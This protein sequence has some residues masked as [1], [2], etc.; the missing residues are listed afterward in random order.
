MEFLTN[1]G[2]L[3]LEGR[4]LPLY[5]DRKMIKYRYLL[6]SRNAAGSAIATSSGS[7]AHA[8]MHP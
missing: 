5:H 3:M 2:I 8:G 7:P 1:L 4:L 6:F